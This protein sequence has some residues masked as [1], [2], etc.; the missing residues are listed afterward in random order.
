MSATSSS[1]TEAPA[2]RCR[3]FGSCGGCSLQDKPYETQLQHKKDKVLAS[4]AGVHGLP[5]LT[6]L[7]A[8]DTWNYRK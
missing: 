7:G 8:P 2:A 3:H 5:E 4:L 6:I 1:P